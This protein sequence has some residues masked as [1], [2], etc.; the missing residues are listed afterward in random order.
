MV[1]EG[2]TDSGAVNRP[3][4]DSFNSPNS[5]VYPLAAA[6]P[7]VMPLALA[8]WTGRLN[9]FLLSTDQSSKSFGQQSCVERL[10]ERFVDTGTIEAGSRAI[11]W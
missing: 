5:Y 11:I 4:V 1:G 7:T 3:A 10:F 2:T 6:S 8:T 9:Q